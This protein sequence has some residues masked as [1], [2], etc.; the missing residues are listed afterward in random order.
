[1]KHI[2]RINE[3]YKEDDVVIY[4]GEECKFMRYGE[5]SNTILIELPSGEPKFVSTYSIEDKNIN[6]LNR[7]PH[8][9]GPSIIDNGNGDDPT[10]KPHILERIF[11]IMGFDIDDNNIVTPS[12]RFAKLLCEMAIRDGAFEKVGDKYKLTSKYKSENPINL[13]EN[14]ME[15]KKVK[16]DSQKEKDEWWKKNYQK[17]ISMCDE[18]PYEN[19]EVLVPKK[20]RAVF[21]DQ[22]SKHKGL[23]LLALYSIKDL[24][25]MLKEHEEDMDGLED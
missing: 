21:S 8:W 11:K 22:T 23:F 1:M 3:F 19:L 5:T 12:N 13:D 16:K 25:E 17:L 18:M 9:D 2:K 24:E 15:A 20:E 14:I 7:A 6:E 10:D 4:K